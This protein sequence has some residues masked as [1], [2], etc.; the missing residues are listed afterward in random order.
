MTGLFDRAQAAY[1]YG[2]LALARE[3]Y[4]K[5]FELFSLEDDYGRGVSAS[6]LA[7]VDIEEARARYLR[8]VYE[9]VVATFLVL[10]SGESPD[11]LTPN[12][13][14]LWQWRL[15]YSGVSW[16]GPAGGTE[17]VL[18]RLERAYAEQLARVRLKPDQQERFLAW[19]LKVMHE[20][21]NAIVG[22]QHRGSYDKAAVLTAACAET[23][24]LRGGPAAAGALVN[25]VRDRFPRHRAF[26][27]ELK[28]AFPRG[29][30]GQAR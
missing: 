11:A 18:P 26:L 2:H 13:A 30:P 1:D 4:E 10:L 15:Q 5:L 17:P 8:A 20:R 14:Q 16:G 22:N 19:C 25:E 9:L 12:L 21:V 27:A 3:A 24:R 6:D 28:K 23:L 7:G 29:R